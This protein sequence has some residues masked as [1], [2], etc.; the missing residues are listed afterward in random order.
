MKL[1]A[2]K[3]LGQHFL[4]SESV[5][6]K[7]E[8]RIALMLPENTRVILEIGPGEGVL[9]ERLLRIAEKKSIKVLAIE[10]DARAI[11]PLQTRFEKEIASGL[12]TIT[13]GDVLEQ[14]S[15]T[16]PKEPYALIANIPYYITGAIFQQFLESTNQ[17]NYML[18]LVQEEVADRICLI[19]SK[20]SILSLSVHAYGKPKKV[21]R[22]PPGAFVPPPNI[23]SAII[24]IS[25]I[26]KTYFN[27]ANV[28]DVNFFTVVSAG[29][30][31]KRKKLASNLSSIAPKEKVEQIFTDLG[32][33]T[34][35]RAE[36]L[37][38]SD[39]I[40]ITKKLF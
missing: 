4:R 20:H 25:G 21:G 8:E 18:M 1:F 31:H 9:T 29:F 7:M 15:S 12:L 3:S 14:N 26:S 27:D 34:N 10:K 16:L 17:P 23:N 35:S 40:A 36:E 2:K 22:V 24:E 32:I 30:A 11:I 37:H 28:E 5:L 39:W 33:S 19:D 6:Y 38:V 13:E